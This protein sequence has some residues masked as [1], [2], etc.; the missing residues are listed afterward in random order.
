M[1]AHSSPVYLEVADRPPFAPEDAAAI[2]TIIDGA[3]TWIETIATVRSPAERRRLAAA[4]AASRAT[5]DD[6]IIRERDA[7]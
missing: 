4:L 2:G 7:G 1:G 3:R 6:L 5:L